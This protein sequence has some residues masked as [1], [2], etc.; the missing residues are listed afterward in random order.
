[1][2]PY[3]GNHSGT[4][5]LPYMDAAGSVLVEIRQIFPWKISISGLPLRN[6]RFGIRPCNVFFSGM[7]LIGHLKTKILKKKKSEKGLLER[8]S[9]KN[10]FYK[11]EF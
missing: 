8:Y 1:M 9:R 6:F 2:Q 11:E 10:K 5:R 7:P 3:C 4:T